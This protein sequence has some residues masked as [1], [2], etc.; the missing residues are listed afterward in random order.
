MATKKNKDVD[1]NIKIDNL[2][3]AIRR[4]IREHKKTK[5]RCNGSGFWVFGS[6]LSIVLSYTQN[7]SIL[8]AIIHGIISWFYVIYR[9]FLQLGWF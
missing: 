8:W 7:S 1:I 4:G 5:V 3:R 9:V 2:E 6:A